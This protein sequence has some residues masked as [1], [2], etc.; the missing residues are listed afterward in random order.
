M[1]RRQRRCKGCRELFTPETSGQCLCDE[2]RELISVG[3][4]KDVFELERLRAKYNRRHKTLIHYGQFV[5]YIEEIRERSR[6]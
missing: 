3:K 1:K 5:R 4:S 6:K 2:C